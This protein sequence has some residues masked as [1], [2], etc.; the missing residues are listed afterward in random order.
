MAIAGHNRM[1]K[2][3]I[4]SHLAKYASQYIVD[5]DGYCW[6]QSHARFSYLIIAF[7]MKMG[8]YL[9]G[10]TKLPNMYQVYHV[11]Y[12]CGNVNR[13]H[14]VVEAICSHNHLKNT[15]YI[16]VA[17]NSCTRILVTVVN[18][19]TLVVSEIDST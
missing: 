19:Y 12:V 2:V 5:G 3:S 9:L 10:H 8:F 13:C 11:M 4:D 18:L 17:R 7:P 15:L 6:T 16:E 1:H 14:Y